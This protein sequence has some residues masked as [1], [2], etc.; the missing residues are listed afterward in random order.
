MKTFLLAFVLRWVVGSQVF[1]LVLFL[2]Y[3]CEMEILCVS[4]TASSSISLGI[5]VGRPL[6]VS[7]GDGP[8][9]GW[10]DR[11]FVITALPSG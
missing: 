6:L 3:M 9:D 1:I 10:L 4:V 5:E 8:L 2:I 11:D 7:S